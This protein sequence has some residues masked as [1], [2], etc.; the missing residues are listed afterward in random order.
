M[1]PFCIL[2]LNILLTDFVREWNCQ[3][4]AL[5]QL[6]LSCLFCFLAFF[7]CAHRTSEVCSCCS[8]CFLETSV[9]SFPQFHILLSPQRFFAPFPRCTRLHSP[10]GTAEVC[11]WGLRVDSIKGGISHVL[12]QREGGKKLELPH[13][14]SVGEETEG[15]V[16]FGSASAAM[17]AW[18]C[19]HQVYSHY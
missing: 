3:A 16:G 9:L 11:M 10:P 14:S 15:S 17:G 2:N 18:K 6:G 19:W 4:W 8:P 1:A 12:S 5:P 13:G 7:F